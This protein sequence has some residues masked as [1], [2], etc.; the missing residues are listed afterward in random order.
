MESSN[1]SA[2]TLNRGLRIF[3][4]EFVRVSL[5][6]PSQALFFARTV[7]WQGRAAQRCARHAAEGLTVPPIAI[8]SITNGCS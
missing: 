1:S 4:S 2:S 5:S 6:R 7:L 8:F 3:F